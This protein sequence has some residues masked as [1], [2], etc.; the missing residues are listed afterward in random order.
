MRPSLP[1]PALWLYLGDDWT[2]STLRGMSG[3]ALT[4]V[5][6]VV[7]AS[8]GVSPDDVSRVHKLLALLAAAH[9]ESA[10]R[11]QLRLVAA[12][13]GRSLWSRGLRLPADRRGAQRL[14]V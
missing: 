7:P 14:V 9:V 6:D 8:G 11:F 10:Q 1:E 2:A 3:P 12:L 5:G 13:W 4:P